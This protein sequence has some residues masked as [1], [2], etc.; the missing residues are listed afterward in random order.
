MTGCLGTN[1][2]EARHHLL[3]CTFHYKHCGTIAVF[4]MYSGG[5]GG[6]SEHRLP[7]LLRA[8]DSLNAMLP[9]VG[10]LGPLGRTFHSAKG[11]PHEDGTRWDGSFQ[12]DPLQAKQWHGGRAGELESAVLKELKFFS[13]GRRNLAESFRADATVH[14]YGMSADRRAD[15]AV[16]AAN[17]QF[18]CALQA[19]AATAKND[20]G[21]NG[22]NGPC[23]RPTD[24][25]GRRLHR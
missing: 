20:S 16:A 13:P 18:K 12:L 1:A 22:P 14:Y 6:R 2:S 17:R 5:P 19:G 25:A 10:R 21:V 4:V 9:R 8:A 11:A 24:W 23:R 15:L 3:A 7:N